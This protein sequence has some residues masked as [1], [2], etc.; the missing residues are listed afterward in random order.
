MANVSSDSSIKLK[1]LRDRFYIYE[2]YRDHINFTNKEF[3]KCFIVVDVD[4]SSTN[5][6]EMVEWC[7]TNCKMSDWCFNT[8]GVGFRSETDASLF[9]LLVK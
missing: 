8:K 7:K 4:F 1:R 9:K 5:V 6:N 3:R 2:E